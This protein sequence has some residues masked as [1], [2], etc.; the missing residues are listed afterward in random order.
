MNESQVHRAE[1]C[2]ALHEAIAAGRTAL[3]PFSSLAVE[4][5]SILFYR[6][7]ACDETVREKKE[8]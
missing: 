6:C 3:V 8:V 7:P 4:G 2:A 5:K 1:K